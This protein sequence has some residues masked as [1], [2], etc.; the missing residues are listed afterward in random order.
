MK[1][2]VVLYPAPGTGHVISMVELGKLILNHH[3]HQFL[4][5][6]LLTTGHF[7]NPVTTSYI[8][9]ISQTN[10]SITFHHFP[11]I[12]VSLDTSPHRSGP[13]IAFEFIRLNDPNV[14]HALQSISQTSTIRALVIDF[15]CT[16]A[17]H[18]ASDLSI[19]TY[20]FCTSGAAV[21]AAFLYLPTIHN[22][23]TKSFKDLTTT[24]L[25]FP[26]LPPIRASHMPRPLL[27][28][29]DRAYH[30]MLYFASHLPKSKGLIMN[31]FEALEPRAIKAIAEGIC[32]PDAPTPPIYYVG[33]LMAD[34]DNRTG[35]GGDGGASNCL[36]WLDAQPSRSVVFLCFGSWGAFSAAQLKE[37]ANGLE[38][39]GHRFLWVVRNPPTG[40][41]SNL[42]SAA[43]DSDLDALLPE[44][45]LDRTQGRGLVISSWAPQVAVLS[46]ESVGGFVTHCGWNSVLEAVCAGVPMVAWPLYAEQHMNKAVLVE[47]MKLAIPMEQSDENGFVSATEIKKRVKEL[48]DSEEGRALRRR[49]QEMR[50]SAMAA[51]SEFGSSMTAL[52]ELAQSWKRG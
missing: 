49:S 6:V 46:R 42:F 8:S 32:V 20:Y 48:M 19:P 18:I 12:S 7:D 43:E 10:P 35:E 41:N 34:S 31:T 24:L 36:S 2:S 17:L 28:R 26:G 9:H 52:T 1:E 3:N 29:N 15:F 21:F 23:T 37:I 11:S 25:H 40:G 14:R 27:D 13:A 16:S 22:Q 51:W 50:E 44:G 45:F 4:V 33:P 38:K 47:D 30:D 39:S 5:T